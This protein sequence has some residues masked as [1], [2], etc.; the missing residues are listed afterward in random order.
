MKFLIVFAILTSCS[1]KAVR[2]KV[3]H[4]NIKELDSVKVK[5]GLKN[6]QIK[7]SSEIVKSLKPDIFSINE[8]Q[9]DKIG[10]PNSSF[11]TEGENLTNLS[12]LFGFDP[13]KSF[14]SFNEA[15]TGKNAKRKNGA[16]VLDPNK[17][18]RN[19][20]A[21]L[22]NFGLI[23]GQY[24]TGGIFKYPIK[25]V[26]VFSD[27]KWRDFNPE[28]NLSK[29]KDS[30]GNSLPLDM[31]LFD[32]NFT[33]I[34]LDVLGKD[35]HIILLHTVP[36]FGFGNKLTPNFKRNYD[37][38]EFLTW[39]LTGKSEFKHKLAIKPLDEKSRFIAMGDWNV[40]YQSTNLGAKKLKELY[41]KFSPWLKD[42]TNTYIGQKFETNNFQA[43]LDYILVSN[44]IKILNS[45]VYLPLEQREDLGCGRTPR[46][47]KRFS[48]VLVSYQN[49]E[50]QKCY[51]W[52][53]KEFYKTKLASDHLPIW[54]DLEI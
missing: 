18:E 20:L 39:Y 24:S 35:V 47:Y 1:S 49:N 19:Q 28:I 21:D 29:F 53:S 40:D 30:L 3:V 25:S 27:I 41:E 11:T 51:A 31:E 44:N 17:D 45:G 26:K 6:L 52:V 36:A 15:N 42:H 12:K 23:P 37:Q 34:T 38:L 10:N 16:Y 2:L 13:H 9:F 48:K 8:L 7:F 33:D 46:K 43:Q 5:A 32:K 14:Y 50:N 22:I 54:A 4:Y